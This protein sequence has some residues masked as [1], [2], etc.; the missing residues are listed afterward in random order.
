MNAT[1]ESLAK[2]INEQ[3]PLLLKVNDDLQ[4]KII[5]NPKFDFLMDTK[6]VA[7]GY[8]ISAETLRSVKH[9]HKDEIFENEHFVSVAKCNGGTPKTFYTK[10]GVIKV[11]FF[12]T[13][14]RAKFFR[15]WAENVILEIIAPKEE[16]MPVIIKRKHNRLT[17][18]RMISILAD[19][20]QIDD[21]QL[22]LSLISKL[23]VQ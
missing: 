12:I 22:R 7:S 5:T 4:V 9:R 3:T 14:E 1:K 2:T 21:K 23:G 15:R 20:A 11:G 8:G 17:Q 16:N 10:K 13:S 19:I 18:E 6:T